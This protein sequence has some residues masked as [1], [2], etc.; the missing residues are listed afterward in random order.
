[1]AESPDPAGA[2]GAVRSFYD[3][4]VEEHVPYHRSPR[5]LQR[6]VLRVLP[7]WSYREWRFWE[8]TV[9][10][11]ENLLDLGCARGRQVFRDKARRVIGVDLAGS[12]LV[13]CVERYDGAALAALQALPFAAGAFDC[14]VSSHVLG[15]VPPELKP[16]VFAE[17]ARVLRPGGVSVHVIETESA[18]ALI[19]AAKARPDLYQRRILDPDGHVGLE[20]PS[21]AVER[22]RAAGFAVTAIEK[23]DARTLH[24]RLWVKWFDNEYRKLDLDID[25]RV[26]RAER[27]LASPWKLAAAEV[28][29]GLWHRTLGQ[30]V[31]ALDEAMFVAVAARAPQSGR[32]S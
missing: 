3:E 26:R 31:P 16:R 2:V 1:M 27:A 7:Y 17:M 28:G 24:P 9:P 12:A 20:A 25:R 19:R 14:V 8:R 10:R 30:W 15:H 32:R 18:G 22:F 6:A 21:Q 11:C 4:Y 29:L 13:E 5:G 23:M